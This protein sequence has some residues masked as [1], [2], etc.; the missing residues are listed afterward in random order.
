MIEYKLY[1][2][3]LGAVVGIIS[4]VTLITTISFQAIEEYSLS[5]YPIVGM[6]CGCCVL[7]LIEWKRFCK[8]GESG[9]END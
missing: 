6:T 9:N 1:L 5:V 3:Y 2:Y 4:I 7:F 8:R